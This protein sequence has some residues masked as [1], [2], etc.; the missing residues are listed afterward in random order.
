MRN[1]I[2]NYFMSDYNRSRE[3]MNIVSS[4]RITG[5]KFNLYYGVGCLLL[6]PLVGIGLGWYIF[7]VKRHEKWMEE[8]KQMGL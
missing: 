6:F 7:E 1:I 2:K 4:G 8:F 3:A 5:W